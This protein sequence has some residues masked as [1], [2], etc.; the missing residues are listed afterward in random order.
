MLE[1]ELV[2]AVNRI[3]E[4]C[5][6]SDVFIDTTIRHLANAGPNSFR[7]QVVLFRVDTTPIVQYAWTLDEAVNAVIDSY[8]SLNAEKKDS[9]KPVA[10]GTD[11][12]K[13]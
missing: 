2:A 3:E 5:G 12:V 8:L 1:N 7:Y 9:E 13:K 6:K 4:K 10:G 11:P